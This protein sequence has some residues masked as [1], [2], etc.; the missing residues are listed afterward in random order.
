MRFYGLFWYLVKVLPCG[1]GLW[2]MIDLK[3]RFVWNRIPTWRL[4]LITWR[5]LLISSLKVRFLPRSPLGCEARIW[6]NWPS[7]SRLRYRKSLYVSISPADYTWIGT[8]LCPKTC[9]GFGR[10]F[11]NERLDFSLLDRSPD[12]LSALPTQC[13]SLTSWLI[14]P[15]CDRGPHWCLFRQH[16][17][18]LCFVFRT[19]T[20]FLPMKEYLVLMCSFLDLAF[21]HQN[22]RFWL[23]KQKQQETPQFS[24]I[25]EALKPA[26]GAGVEGFKFSG[27]WL[28]VLILERSNDFARCLGHLSVETSALTNGKHPAKLIRHAG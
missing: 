17:A 15:A 25:N 2:Q 14:E 5:L 27:A 16:F 23:F 24:G 21:E 19:K 26:L 3:A 8:N 10:S 18:A 9:H 6:S 11:E 13:W 22:D 12:L 1:L 4:L 7:V 28:I 20:K